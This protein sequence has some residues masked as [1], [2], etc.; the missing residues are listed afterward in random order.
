M[1]WL[2]LILRGLLPVAF[3]IGMGVL[4]AAVQAGS[5]L[6]VPLAFAVLRTI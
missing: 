2:L 6:A 4:V 3:G 5:G 1:W